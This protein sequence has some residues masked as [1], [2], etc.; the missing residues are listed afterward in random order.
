[1]LAA[2]C[3]ML[4]STSS[5]PTPVPSPTAGTAPPSGKAA[6]GKPLLLLACLDDPGFFAA[7][8]SRDV[9]AAR[10]LVIYQGSGDVNGRFNEDKLRT[11]V[12]K[13][14][15]ADYDGFGVLDF[16]VPWLHNLQKDPTSP[17]FAEAQETLLR[18]LATARS[19]RPNVKWTLYGL[20]GLPF[21]VHGPR[22]SV[23]G[24]DK[25][26]KE[27]EDAQLAIAR[28]AQKVVDACDWVS[29]SI[30]C[31]Y[32]YSTNPEWTEAT[33][34]RAAACTTL[35]IEMAKGKPVFPMVWHRVH[36]SNRTDGLKML[37][38]S[39][40]MQG[41]VTPALKA[42]ATGVV[43][44]GADAYLARVGKLPEAQSNGTTAATGRPTP[45]AAATQQQI[46][47]AHVKKLDAMKQAF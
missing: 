31:P 34:A 45:T 1:M 28:R 35:A 16:E 36:D 9:N 38:D 15:P 24:W 13:L 26:T 40:F 5:T 6:P 23:V 22:G 20:P 44:W 32:L 12:G 29:P 33:P 43:W 17:E 47:D 4:D 30:Y 3:G 27:S 37:P 14:I 10:C 39:Q 18:I 7:V 21:F 19:V 25:G 41:Q 8:R 46:L 2:S 42:G 11:E